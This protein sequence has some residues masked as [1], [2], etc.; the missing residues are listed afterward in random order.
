MYKTVRS[1]RS[2]FPLNTKNRIFKS[3]TAKIMFCKKVPKT[4]RIKNYN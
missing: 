2:L 3:Y 4:K 1:F